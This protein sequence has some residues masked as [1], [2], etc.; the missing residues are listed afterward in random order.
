M[1]L[2]SFSIGTASKVPH[3]ITE[4]L[5][6]HTHTF[7]HNMTMTL[8]N[9]KTKPFTSA[10]DEDNHVNKMNTLCINMRSET[11]STG[12]SDKKKTPSHQDGCSLPCGLHCR[13]R[14]V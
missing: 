11:I 1:P 13:A 5:V 7:T 9:W 14:Y 12:K 8:R 2:F 3:C 4:H 6:R 10:H